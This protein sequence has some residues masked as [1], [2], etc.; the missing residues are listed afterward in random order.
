MEHVRRSS[1]IKKIGV[2]LFVCAL[3]AGGVWSCSDRPLGSYFTQ[4]NITPFDNQRDMA[5][6]LALFERNIYWLDVNPDSSL[7]KFHMKYRTPSQNPLEFGKLYTRVLR[8][9]GKLVGFVSYYMGK[10]TVGRVLYVVV[11]ESYRGKRYGQKLLEYAM[12][13][14]KKMGARRIK[15]V[16]RPHNVPGHALYKR[17]G[18]RETRRTD[19]HSYFE[20]QVK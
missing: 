1:W 2:A 12:S 5:E 8:E 18:F 4:S 19:I 9:H 15:L 3:L 11:D 7:F 20:Y 6:M 14:L 16:T 10:P 17:V 13:D